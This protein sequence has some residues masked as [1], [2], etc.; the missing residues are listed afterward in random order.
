LREREGEWIERNLLNSNRASLLDQ[1]RRVLDSFG[2]EVLRF[3]GIPE[4]REEFAK[5]VRDTRNYFTHFSSDRPARVPDGKAL[6]VLQ[7]RVWFLLR[8]CLLRDMGFE[9]PEIV[10]LLGDAGQRYYLIR[11]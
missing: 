11:G 4:D 6:I 1:V 7:H 10:E 5:T 3:C 8:A 2:G 9:E